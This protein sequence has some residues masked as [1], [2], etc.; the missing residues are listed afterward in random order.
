MGWVEMGARL[1]GAGSEEA[2]AVT[3][4]AQPTSHRL[5]YLLR[6]LS[7]FGSYLLPSPV[8]FREF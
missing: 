4:T 1:T 5:L 6:L 7:V 8:P 2:E 3:T